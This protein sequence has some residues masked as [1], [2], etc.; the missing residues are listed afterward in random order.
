MVTVMEVFNNIVLGR[1][2]FI[3]LLVMY[4]LQVYCFYR[5]ISFFLFLSFTPSPSFVYEGFRVKELLHCSFT[6]C[7]T[8][9]IPF[10]YETRS[11]G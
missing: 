5:Y 2:L 8:F 4:G 11:F 9:L 10:F 1:Y 3:I 7:F 6:R